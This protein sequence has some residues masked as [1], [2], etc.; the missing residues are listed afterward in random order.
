MCLAFNP[1]TEPM[2]VD[3]LVRL[4]SEMAEIV[5]EPGNCGGAAIL[6]EAA[7]HLKVLQT[8]M[9]PPYPSR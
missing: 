1:E 7:E 3:A 6:L 8:L 9:P 5:D 2:K 4:L